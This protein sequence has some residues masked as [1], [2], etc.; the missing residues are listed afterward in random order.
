MQVAARL[1]KHAGKQHLG[2][3]PG[4]VLVQPSGC[5]SEQLPD[6]GRLRCFVH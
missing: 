6:G 2:I 4:G 5:M 1:A 3:E